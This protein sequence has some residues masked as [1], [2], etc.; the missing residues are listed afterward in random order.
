M[1]IVEPPGE[2]LPCARVVVVFNATPEERQVKVPAV[3]GSPLA[4][5]EVQRNG[6][7]EIVKRARVTA[8]GGLCVPA[9]TTAV[10]VQPVS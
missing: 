8:T 1:Q 5:H 6:A 9:R 10:F 2:D 7:D 4:L 3:E